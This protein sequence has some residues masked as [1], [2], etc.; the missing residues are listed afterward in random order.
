MIQT[1]EQ[2]ESEFPPKIPI[3]IPNKSMFKVDEICSLIGVKP[4]VLRFW[5]S[6]FESINPVL[7]STGQ[8]LYDHRDIEVLLQIKKFLFD[9]KMMIEKAKA[10]IKKIFEKNLPTSLDQEVQE[11]PAELTRRNLSFLDIEKLSKSKEILISITTKLK[12]KNPLIDQVL[13]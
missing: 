1:N 9:Q 4:Y 2:N 3:E 13:H 10:E 7:S 12:A 8:K 6:E 5:E 11:E